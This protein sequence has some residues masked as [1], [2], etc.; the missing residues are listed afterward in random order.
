[1]N[2]YI[3]YSD[4]NKFKEKVRHKMVLISMAPRKC[5]NE[6]NQRLHKSTL[7]GI[8]KRIFTRDIRYLFVC[9]IVGPRAFVVKLRTEQG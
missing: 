8:R 6:V 3:K 5:P 7:E 2:P 4:N 1:M 9:V